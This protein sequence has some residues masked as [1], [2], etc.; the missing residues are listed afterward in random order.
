MSQP[1]LYTNL[2]LLLLG[3]I[4]H[5]VTFTK[6]FFVQYGNQEPPTRICT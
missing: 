2:G 6:N 3:I 1:T 4:S 5:Y